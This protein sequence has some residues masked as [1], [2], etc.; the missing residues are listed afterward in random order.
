M[1][2]AVEK[3]SCRLLWHWY[4]LQKNGLFHIR[5]VL[6]LWIKIIKLLC[7]HLVGIQ[8]RQ[9]IKQCGA[10]GKPSGNNRSRVDKSEFVPQMRAIIVLYM[11]GL[12]VGAPLKRKILKILKK[13][14]Y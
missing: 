12:V 2:G 1:I 8:I 3:T 5:Y 9:P 4:F 11:L 7:P 13:Y 6:L 14:F 10:S